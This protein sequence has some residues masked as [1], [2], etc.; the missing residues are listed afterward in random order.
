[1][2]FFGVQVREKNWSGGGFFLGLWSLGRAG[3]AFGLW[4]REWFALGCIAE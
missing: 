2:S 1:M 3:G 4:L